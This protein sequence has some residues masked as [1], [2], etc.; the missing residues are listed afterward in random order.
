M[1]RQNHTHSS[2]LFL[3]ELILAI[4]FFTLASAVCLQIFVKSHT[5]SRLAQDLNFAVNAVSSAAE[6]VPSNPDQLENTQIY[7]DEDY[8]LCDADHAAFILSAS[9]E[10]EDSHI[11]GE[12]SVMPADDTTAIYTIKI[13]KHIQRR[14]CDV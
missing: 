10:V 11:L 13:Y 2:G 8:G 6:Q 12:I 4:L 7:Y 1:K 14:A 3:L 9:F 5:L